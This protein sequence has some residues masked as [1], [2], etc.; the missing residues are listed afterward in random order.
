MLISFMNPIKSLEAIKSA[1]FDHDIRVF[2]TDTLD[3]TLKIQHATNDA[4]DLTIV[5]R[6]DMFRGAACQLTKKFGCTD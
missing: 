5:V 1:Y 4:S 3:E 2:V 6:L